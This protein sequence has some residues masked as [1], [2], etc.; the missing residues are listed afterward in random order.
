MAFRLKDQDLQVKLDD[1][2]GGDFTQ[3]LQSRAK[4]K[5][6]HVMLDVPFRRAGKNTKRYEAYFFADEIEEVP[7]YNPH[8][9]NVWPDTTPPEDEMMR[10]EIFEP[11][12]SGDEK[13]NPTKVLYHLCATFKNRE[14]I[15]QGEPLFWYQKHKRDWKVRFRPWEF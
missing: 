8:E 12:L 6:L 1:I 11:D 3:S 13:Y 7:D 2:S 14:W 15:V 10:I 9:W 4:Y 5:D